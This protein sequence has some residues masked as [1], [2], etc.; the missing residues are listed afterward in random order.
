MVKPLVLSEFIPGNPISTLKWAL[1][2]KITQNQKICIEGKEHVEIVSTEFQTFLQTKKCGSLIQSWDNPS[3]VTKNT[4]ILDL[5]HL[6]SD[7]H[8]EQL[9]LM[10]LQRIT[11]PLS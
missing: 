6:G 10:Q 8:M 2:K 7:Y 9:S 11:P 1:I 4:S 3:Q 5:E